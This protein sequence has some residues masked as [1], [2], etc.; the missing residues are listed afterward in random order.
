MRNLQL[1]GKSEL[2]KLPLTL[3]NLLSYENVLNEENMLL[4]YIGLPG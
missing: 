4:P 2:D 3:I 1:N